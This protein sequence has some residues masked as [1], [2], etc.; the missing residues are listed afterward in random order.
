VV[1]L[2]VSP[3]CCRSREI[4]RTWTCR[5]WYW[6]QGLGWKKFRTW[7][8]EDTISS[9]LEG[10]WSATPTKWS[11]N[12]L[13]IFSDLNGSWPRVLVHISGNLRMG[14]VLVQ[15][16]MLNPSKSHAPFMLDLALR[17]DLSMN[18]FRDTLKIWC[19]SRCICS[20]WFKLMHRD[21]GPIVRYLGKDVPKEELI[22]QDPIAVTQNNR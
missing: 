12:T 8:G 14:Q 13:R 2:L 4:R 11:N 21:M 22:W 10:A 7:E 15:Y 20:C 9:G 5:S 3:W 1:T 16:Q 6:R 17:V 19:I 18:Q